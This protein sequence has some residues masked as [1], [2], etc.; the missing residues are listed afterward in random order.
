MSP[1]PT[2]A[3][4]GFYR[5]SGFVHWPVRDYRRADSSDRYV[6]YCRRPGVKVSYTP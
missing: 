2:T 5:E 6:I 4:P 3:A 1:H